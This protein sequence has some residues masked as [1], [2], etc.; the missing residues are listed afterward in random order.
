[1]RVDAFA[2]V[3]LSMAITMTIITFV[4]GVRKFGFAGWLSIRVSILAG[5]LWPLALLSTLLCSISD[6]RKERDGN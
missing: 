2:F 6:K 3:Y 5:V 4:Y 1:M